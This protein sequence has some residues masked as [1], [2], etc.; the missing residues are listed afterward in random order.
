[1]RINLDKSCFLFNNVDEGV[2]NSISRSLSVSYDHISLG[3]KYLGF[4]IK[5]LNYRVKDWQWLISNFERRIQHWTFRLLSLGGRLVL[6]KVVLPSLP[7]YWMALIPIPSS[8]LDKL[9]YL[10]ISFLWGSSVEQKKFHLVDWQTLSKPI[11]LGGWGIKHMGLFSLS[12]RLKSFWMALT[13]T[14]IWHQL[15]S[16][17][18]LKG[19]SVASWLR[20]NIFKA[21]NASMIWKGFIHT[22]SW[23]GCGLARKVGN[24]EDIRVGID[25][26]MGT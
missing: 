13:G 4:F 18:Y 15:L 16:V 1:M 2:L 6:I 23:I 20:S 5:P 25:L 22:I 7:V 12:I 10:I 14:G 24:S 11:S 26:I 8:V 17:K 19:L 9:R 3:F 21:T